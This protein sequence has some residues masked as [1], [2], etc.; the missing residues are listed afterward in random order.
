[1]EDFKNM[2]EPN[3]KALG[4]GLVLRDIVKQSFQNIQESI[5]GGAKVKLALYSRGGKENVLCGIQKGAGD[6]CMLYVHHIESI[7]HDRLKF[8]GKGKHAKRIKFANER[9]IIKE[10]IEWLFSQ[11]NQ[12]APY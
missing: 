8:S 5:S 3:S 11:V 6:S 7:T 10:D 1:M 4:M 12:N 2:F 9:E